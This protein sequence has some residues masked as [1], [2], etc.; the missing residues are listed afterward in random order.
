MRWGIQNDAYENH[1]TTELCLKEITNCQ[2][3][4]LGPNF[5]VTY[6]ATE[7]N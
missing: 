2:N 6:I 4:S 5:I 3:V 7:R 1:G